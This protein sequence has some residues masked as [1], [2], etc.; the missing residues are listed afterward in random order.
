MTEKGQTDS[1]NASEPGMMKKEGSSYASND[2]QYP[3]SNDIEC[4]R[5]FEFE[6]KGINQIPGIE[7][8]DLKNLVLLNIKEVT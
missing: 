1:Y 5:Y 3:Q 2:E 8:A 7:S 4:I 6:I